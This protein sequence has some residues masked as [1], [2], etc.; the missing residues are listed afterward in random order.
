MAEAEAAVAIVHAQGPEESVLL[1]RRAVRDGDPW[2]GHW[3]LPGGRRDPEDHDLLDTSLRELDEEC[4]IR[5]ERAQLETALPPMIARRPA[6]PY[7][8]VA[9]FVFRIAE[10]I[11]A[12]ADPR[13]AVEARWIDLST[14]RDPRSHALQCVP[15]RPEC[16]LFPGINLDGTPLWG[17]TYRLLCDWLALGP[18]S[19]SAGQASL[20]FAT[21]V[22]RFVLD[23]G[24]TLVENWALRVAVVRGTLPDEAVL[25]RF[26]RPSQEIPPVNRLEV[27]P[28]GIRI[29]GLNFEEYRIRVAD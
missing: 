24:L 9:P 3:S 29:A 8:L 15:G 2:S 16:D 4:G 23:S 22:L 26:S 19:G 14:L 12:V 10:R 13:E 27:R 6:P 25:A 28:D 1:I 21:C 18:R 17:F 5:L 20:D 11:H 7:L